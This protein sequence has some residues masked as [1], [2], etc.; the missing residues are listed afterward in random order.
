M[1]FLRDE[2][3]TNFPLLINGQRA[4]A[5]RSARFNGDYLFSYTPNPGTVVFLGYGSQADA[6]PDPVDR[7]TYQPL[8][9][10][11]DHFFVKVSYLFRM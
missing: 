7:F 6:P 11:S 3:R 10:G 9:R 2:T 1:A 5:S 4:M 8:V